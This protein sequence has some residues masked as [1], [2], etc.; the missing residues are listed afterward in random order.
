MSTIINNIKKHTN[1]TIVFCAVLY[2]LSLCSFLVQ[3]AVEEKFAVPRINHVYYTINDFDE[4][5]FISK[6]DTLKSKNII[7]TV[8]IEN[9]NIKT[10]FRK[11]QFT[12]YTIGEQDIV[13]YDSVKNV[14]PA[15]VSFKIT[16]DFGL[17]TGES[18]EKLKLCNYLLDGT[19]ESDK[20]IIL[21]ILRGIPIVVL[22]FFP[23]LFPLL[24]FVLLLLWLYEKSVALM[25]RF[26]K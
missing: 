26:R 7:T 20:H 19:C 22:I 9:R 15:A 4:N 5:A 12:I 18:I 8:G 17:I 21:N 10:S 16:T 23:W 2:I 25:K 11:C 6:I 24:G 13:I 1:R 3:M 14:Y